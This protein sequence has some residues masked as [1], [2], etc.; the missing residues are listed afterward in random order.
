[1][2]KQSQSCLTTLVSLKSESVLRCFTAR[3]ACP[4]STILSKMQQNST[5][6]ILFYLKYSISF[7]ICSE[8]DM[9]KI[10]CQP[11]LVFTD[12]DILPLFCQYALT[13]N[14]T[15]RVSVLPHVRGP[16]YCTDR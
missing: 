3:G 4:K 9:F 12:S 11:I 6:T 13:S 7:F 5:K 15:E 2:K 8:S 14:C 10:K 16:E 1:M